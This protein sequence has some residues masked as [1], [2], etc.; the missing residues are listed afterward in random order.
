MAK[1]D[2]LPVFIAVEN[3]YSPRDR[4]NANSKK[5]DVQC[6]RGVNGD[7]FLTFLSLGQGS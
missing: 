1:F 5:I 2:Q 6:P 4:D 7:K 3:F